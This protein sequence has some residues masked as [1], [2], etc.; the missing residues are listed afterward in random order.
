MLKSTMSPDAEFLVTI[1]QKSTF[2]WILN[3]SVF[4]T[5]NNCTKGSTF[6]LISADVPVE[7]KIIVLKS[8]RKKKKYKIIKEFK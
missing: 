1:T 3:I 4:K 7:K 2:A 8:Q 6:R 5:D